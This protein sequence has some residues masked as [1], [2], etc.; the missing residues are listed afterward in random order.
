MWVGPSFPLCV[1]HEIVG[2]ITK[3][4]KDVKDFKVGEV[5]GVGH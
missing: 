5:V 2:E 4:G 1:G 3:V